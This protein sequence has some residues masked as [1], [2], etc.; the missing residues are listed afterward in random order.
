[1]ACIG[2]GRRRRRALVFQ[3]RPVIVSVPTIL[4][5][6]LLGHDSSSLVQELQ[7]SHDVSF[8]LFRQ[9]ERRVAIYRRVRDD[10][11]DSRVML[12]HLL[13]RLRGVVVSVPVLFLAVFDLRCRVCGHLRIGL[14]SSERS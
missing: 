14:S 7:E 11:K 3:T 2:I 1:M 4:S 5:I 8:V 10:F 9:F 6:F 13:Q 12:H